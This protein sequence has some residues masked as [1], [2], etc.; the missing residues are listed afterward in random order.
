MY[1]KR[2][3]L[4]LMRVHILHHASEKMGIFGVGI[5]NELATHGY[6]VSPGTIYPILHEME[7]KNL[8]RIKNKNVKGKIRKIYKTTTKGEK[9][10]KRLKKF[11]IEL[12]EEVV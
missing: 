9:T 2:I 3:L 11:L 5:I 4:G 6:S 1:E 12:Y 8:L 10:L 7:Q